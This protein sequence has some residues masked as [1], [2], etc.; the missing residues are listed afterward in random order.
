MPRPVV[1]TCPLYIRFLLAAHYS[2]LPEREFTAG[3]W[4]N[5]QDMR[6]DLKARGLVDADFQTTP[7]GVRLVGRLGAVTAGDNSK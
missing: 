7:A 3:E 5:G 1:R 2:A 6:D 4:R